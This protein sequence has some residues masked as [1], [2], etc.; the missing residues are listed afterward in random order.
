VPNTV[1]GQF[2]LRVKYD[3]APFDVTIKPGKLVLE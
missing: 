2:D 3:T 1:K